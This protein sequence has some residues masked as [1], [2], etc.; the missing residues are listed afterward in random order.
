[1]RMTSIPQSWL[2]TLCK[3]LLLTVTYDR[4]SYFFT[5]KFNIGGTIPVLAAT[6]VANPTDQFNIDGS[7]L[8]VTMRHQTFDEVPS[9]QHR[10]TQIELHNLVS[11]FVC[12]FMH[13]VPCRTMVHH[14]QSLPPRFLRLTNP[15]SNFI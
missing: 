7:F 12:Q 11:L 3:I 5:N 9:C 8:R 13:T 6:K 15:T 2:L 14:K 10:I 1:M 4:H